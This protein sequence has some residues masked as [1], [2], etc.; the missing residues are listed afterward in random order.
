MDVLPYGDR[1][2]LIELPDLA[3]VLQLD[4][5]L[6][7]DPPPGVIDIV[8]AARTV[9]L[10]LQIGV[11]IESVRRRLDALATRL[12]LPSVS[13]RVADELIEIPTVYDG[14]DLAGV[15]AGLEV[16]PAEVVETH[17]G[18]VWTVAFCGFAP[19]FAYLTGADERLASVPRRATPRTRVP[20]G[21]VAL[22]GGYSA[23]YPGPSPGG[24]ALLGRTDLT[25]FDPDRDPPAL[26]VPGA[27]VRF[28]PR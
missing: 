17:S 6:R 4:A 13:S 12:V 27:R 15:A 24:W 21:S 16:S 19:G 2:L 28:V 14:P 7:L 1:A 20:A 22:A 23:V 8:P 25:V 9:L 26:L 10:R 18:Q 11:E 3:T 5:V